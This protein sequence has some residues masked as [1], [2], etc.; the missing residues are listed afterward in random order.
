MGT[1]LT[2]SIQED[3]GCGCLATDTQDRAADIAAMEGIVLSITAT[4]AVMDDSM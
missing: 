3:L 1:W 2:G 4:Q